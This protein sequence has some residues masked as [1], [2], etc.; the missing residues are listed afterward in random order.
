MAGDGR[1]RSVP[2]SWV[3]PFSEDVFKRGVAVLRPP[4]EFG[5]L[6]EMFSRGVV[7]ALHFISSLLKIGN[8]GVK[9]TN[10]KD[11]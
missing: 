1:T 10:K 6:L 7:G 5:L 4:F 3:G 8:K 11:V 9:V 2:F